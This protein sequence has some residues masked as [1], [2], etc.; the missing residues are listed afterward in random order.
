[1]GSL[2]VTFVQMDG[3]VKTVAD[4]DAGQSLMTVARANGVAGI[5]G[6]CGG[7]CSCATCH[8]Y[9]DA[10]WQGQVGGPDEV[11]ASTLDMVS[12]L[13]RPSSRLCC[14]IVLRPEL[15]GVKVAVAPSE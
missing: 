8:V 6:D 13:I 12:D 3:V 4:A 15:D 2:R 5:M 10:D 7:C 11:E 1:M 14:Q 9:V